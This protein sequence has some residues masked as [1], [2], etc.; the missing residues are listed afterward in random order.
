L[1]KAADQTELG[2]REDAERAERAERAKTA[3]TAGTAK[4]AIFGH[5]PGFDVRITFKCVLPEV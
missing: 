1:G 4:A 2:A 5:G 3:K